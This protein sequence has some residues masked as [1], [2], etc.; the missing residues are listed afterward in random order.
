MLSSSTQMLFSSRNTLIDSLRNYVLSVIC[1]SVCPFR[2]THKID[3]HNPTSCQF[4]TYLHLLKL[5]LKKGSPGGLDSKDS[6]CNAGD[7]GSIPGL[8]RSPGE[9]NGY[10]LQYSCLVNPLDRG[11]WWATFSPWDHKR[12][13]SN[14]ATKQQQYIYIHTNIFIT[15]QGGIV[16]AITVPV[17]VTDHMV[18]AG[19]FNCLL[20]L[21][22]TYSLFLPQ[23]PQLIVVLYL[24]G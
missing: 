9:G 18:I 23:A 20:P 6:T 11:A 3:Y 14:T 17:S 19:I 10:P 16:M 24:M 5:Y 4:N 13:G 2:L 21:L 1:I 22:I 7:Q 8:G 15:K 12:V